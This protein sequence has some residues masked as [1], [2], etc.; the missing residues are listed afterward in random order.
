MT[1]VAKVATSTVAKAAEVFLTTKQCNQWLRR[2]CRQELAELNKLHFDVKFVNQLANEPQ[3]GP[4]M[5]QV[6]AAMFE[7]D[8]EVHH[9]IF[10]PPN[11]PYHRTPGLTKNDLSHLVKIMWECL[12]GQLLPV[13]KVR[14]RYLQLN[15]QK[16][17]DTAFL[18]LQAE[19][20]ADRNCWV[21]PGAFLP[22]PH[23]F[24][25]H[26]SVKKLQNLH[27]NYHLF[28][29]LVDN[30]GLCHHFV[31]QMVN[32]SYGGLQS[33]ALPTV[34]KHDDG[35]HIDAHVSYKHSIHRGDYAGTISWADLEA[36]YGVSKA[37]Y[38]IAF[39][40]CGGDAAAALKLAIDSHRG[41]LS[42][43][44]SIGPVDGDLFAFA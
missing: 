35:L 15:R 25:R 31:E 17:L 24:S 20:F 40:T 32:Q 3:F 11:I 18:D 22:T 42:A 2:T 36:S 6:I 37:M 29:S 39:E 23:E 34:S 30:N 27:D 4:V 10:L 41:K 26:C 13:Y 44:D 38:E 16:D 43:N 5:T 33:G 9:Y 1:A 21:Q 28:M 8:E 7:S 14:E 12:D 19:D